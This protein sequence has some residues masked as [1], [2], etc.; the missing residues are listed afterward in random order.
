MAVSMLIGLVFAGPFLYVLWRNITLGSDLWGE[1]T[2]ASTLRAMTRSVTLATAVSL[3]TAAL[4]TAL[5]WLTTRTDVPGRRLWR[6][7]APLPLV[8]PSFVGAAALLAAV[9]PGGLVEELLGPVGADR[10]PDLNGFDGAW[11][12]LT[13]F[14][15]PYVYLPVAARLTL[16]PSSLEESARLLGRGP[17][18][19]FRTIVL[20]QC[21]GAIWAGT[22]LVFLY[23]ISDFGAVKLLRYNT[24][25]TQIYAN[26][27]FDRS[28]SFALAL[29]LALLAL[30]VVVA[31]RVNARRAVRVEAIGAGRPHVVH[32]GRWRFVALVGLLAVLVGALIGPVATLLYWAVRGL[33]GAAG[34]T[35]LATV[36]APTINTAVIGLITAVV[37]VIVVLPVAFLTTRYRSRTGG[38]A[39][40]FVV[41]GFAIPG[42]VV[43]L[44][45]VFWVLNAPLLGSL[46]QTLPVLIFAYVVHFGAQSMRAAQVAVSGVPPRMGDAARM[47]GAGP[48]RRLSTVDLPLMAPGLVAGAGLVLLSTMKELPATLLL[49][50]TNVDTLSTEI[51][52]AAEDG[53]LTDMSVSALVLVALSGVLTWLLVMRRDPS[54]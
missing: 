52:N 43:A 17:W 53:F 8:F 35:D 51:W 10:M 4:G 48:L 36:A 27:L 20:P 34:S 46:Y 37:A 16:L 7:L 39:N 44:A 6:V 40:T 2:S 33:T 28:Q 31:E 50:P 23:T 15:Y 47:L 42:L 38:V 30:G 19:V 18:S 21:Q 32:L 5:A 45:L 54:R 25:T 1:L 12:V 49:R 13:L 24:L 11:L 26:R 29:I 22:L 14:T 9:A 3:S 41:A